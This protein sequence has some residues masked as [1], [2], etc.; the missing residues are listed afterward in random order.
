MKLVKYLVILCLVTSILGPASGTYKSYVTDGAPLQPLFLLVTV[1]GFVIG[2]FT[3]PLLLLSKLWSL[4][5][6]YFILTLIYSVVIAHLRKGTR[7][8][9]VDYSILLAVVL[10]CTYQWHT[11]PQKLLVNWAWAPNYL[12]SLMLVSFVPAAL[13]S[14]LGFRLV[15]GKANKGAR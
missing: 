1:T 4:L 13:G 12:C 2:L 15:T 7:L 5:V 14:W 9:A 3:F 10:L 8:T 11:F 6:F